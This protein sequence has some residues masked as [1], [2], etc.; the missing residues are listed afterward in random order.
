[1]PSKLEVLL[2]HLSDSEAYH[3]EAGLQMAKAAGGALY[4]LDL[5]AQAVLNRSTNLIP[6]F[7]YLIESQNFIA[8]APLLRLQIDNCIRFH[9]AWLVNDPHAFASAVLRGDHIRRLKDKNGNPMTDRSLL[10]SFAK[11]FPWVTKVYERTSGYIHLSDA[12]VGNLFVGSSA[13]EEGTAEFKWGRG[14]NFPDASLYMEA[15]EAFIAAT[16]AMFYYITGW[17]KTKQG[18]RG[19]AKREPT[20]CSQPQS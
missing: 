11:K 8:A 13:T 10:E 9:G 12:H 7:V 2:K 1:M 14:D 20:W 6:A 18:E 3:L 4:P 17:V 5:L 19:E 15:V 16:D